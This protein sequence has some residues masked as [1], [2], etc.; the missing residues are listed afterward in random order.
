MF[1]TGGHSKHSIALNLFLTQL[2]SL[3]FRNQ[4]F[5]HMFLKNDTDTPDKSTPCDFTFIF[6]KGV[7]PFHTSDMKIAPSATT[8][9]GFQ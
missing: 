8:K 5:L 1:G 3:C 7:R 9:V 4:G 2:Q 6:I